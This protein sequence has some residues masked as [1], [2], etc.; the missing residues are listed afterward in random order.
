MYRVVVLVLQVGMLLCLPAA[1]AQDAPSVTHFLD[2]PSPG[3]NY[4]GVGA[5]HGWI[6]EPMGEL[7][8]RFDDGEP[9]PLLYGAVRSDVLAKGACDHAEVG[10]VTIWNWGELGEGEHTAIAYDDGVLLAEHTFTVATF[11][12]PFLEE[13]EGNCL[14]DDFPA[15]GETAHFTWTQGTQH[16]ELEM[17]EMQEEEDGSEDESGMP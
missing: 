2:V 13:A 3:G 8:I 11:G 1:W 4:S 14:I 16:L 12:V 9:L 6:C 15:P 10:F 5:I 7:T 17:R